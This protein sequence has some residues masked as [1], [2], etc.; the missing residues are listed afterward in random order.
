[1]MG[2]GGKDNFLQPL[3][4]ELEEVESLRISVNIDQP[5]RDKTCGQSTYDQLQKYD[6]CVGNENVALLPVQKVFEEPYVKDV[7]KEVT[8]RGKI[9]TTYK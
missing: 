6:Q 3:F 1:M 5:S 7:K 9:I 8:L 2:I 4:P